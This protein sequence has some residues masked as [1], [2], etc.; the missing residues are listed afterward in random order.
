MINRKLEIHVG[1]YNFI[2]QALV[3]AR[4]FRTEQYHANKVD[5]VETIWV[6]L[7]LINVTDGIGLY[8]QCNAG[9]A[10]TT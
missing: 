9:L 10:R 7:I 1:D 4:F 3:A 5:H 6:G 8:E 2:H